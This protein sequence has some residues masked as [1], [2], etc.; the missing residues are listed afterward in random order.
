MTR[1]VYINALVRLAGGE[2]AIPRFRDDLARVT[3]PSDIDVWNQFDV[4]R[5]QERVTGFEADALRAF[6][7]AAAIA[8]IFLVGQSISRYSTATVAELHVLRAMGMTSGQTRVAAVAG[9]TLA[10]GAGVLLGV[11]DAIVAS[12]WFPIGTAA[13]LEPMP[14][15]DDD[16]SVLIAGLVGVPVLAAAGAPGVGVDRP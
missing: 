12:R 14:G 11:G 2:A 13:G 10:A 1:Q 4:L 5:R 16:W 15:F 6:A 8:A 3:G 7:L 9:P